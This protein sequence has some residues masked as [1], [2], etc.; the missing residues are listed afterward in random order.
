MLQKAGWLGFIEKFNNYHKEI[1]KSF[2]RFFDGIELEIRD[3]KFVVIESF[4]G[5][6]T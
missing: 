4:I 3:I 5:K 1:T 2:T 6:Q